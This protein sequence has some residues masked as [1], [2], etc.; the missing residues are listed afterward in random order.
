MKGIRKERK[1]NGQKEG[2]KDGVRKGI[3]RKGER[4]ERDEGFGRSSLKFRNFKRVIET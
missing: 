2:R 1:N 4:R 3:G